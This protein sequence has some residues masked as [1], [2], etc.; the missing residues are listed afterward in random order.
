MEFRFI[1]EDGE[2]IEP[3]FRGENVFKMISQIGGGPADEE[4]V[5]GDA[6]KADAPITL[7]VRDQAG[8]V[9]FFKVKKSTEMRKI[10]DAYAQRLGVNARNLK[11]T[12]DGERL[13]ETDTPKMLELTDEDQ[14]D[15]FLDQVGGSD[16]E[17]KSADD[18][19]ITL[20]VKEGSG[21]ETAFKVKKSTKMSKIFDTFASRKGLSV[22]MIR[23]MYDGKRV[24]AEDTP[25]MLEME[26]DDQID[27]VLQQEGGGSSR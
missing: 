8:E 17:Q 3:P 21:E 18:V 16:P 19:A 1:N 12:L 5:E 25:K 10:F 26:D 9:M 23:F 22:N 7:K 11:F 6:P 4:G 27:V 24:K 20:R 15:V 14:I 2:R 13:K